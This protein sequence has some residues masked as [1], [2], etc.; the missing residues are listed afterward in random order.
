MSGCGV[1]RDRSQD[2]EVSQTVERLEV[3]ADLNSDPMREMLVVPDIG[4][5]AIRTDREFE[6]PRPDFFYAEAGNDVV[7]LNRTDSGKL[8]VVDEPVEQVW[9]EVEA[10]WAYNG[11]GVE[12]SD[13]HRG[14]IE[15]EWITDEN[16]RPGFFSRM[17]S[18]ITFSEVAG[19]YRDKLRAVV[20]PVEEGS[21][22]Q[23]SITLQHLRAPESRADADWQ[24]DGEDVSYKSEMM[25][26]LLHYLSKSTEKSTA[27]A[28][29]ARNRGSS[30]A[31]LGRD[32]A[33]HPVLKLTSDIDRSWEM[34]SQALTAAEVDVGSADR[35]LG[36]YY[37]TYET[38]VPVEAPKDGTI[39]D[40]FAWLHGDREE[41][42]FDTSGI[43]A[44]MGI[45][46]EDENAIKYSS[47]KV[48][49]KTEQEVLQEA[50]GYKIWLA[51]RVIYVFGD[52]NPAVK[53]TEQDGIITY[54]GRFQIQ[55]TR[56]SSG[57]YVSVLDELAQH[58]P[59]PLAEDL[60]WSIKENLPAG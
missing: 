16:T 51:G 8:I 44:A 26:D 31:F 38:T 56:R 10:F 30:R 42:T 54:A 17:L 6:V 57:V 55:L 27:K 15:T 34:L 46:S 23:T 13:T 36:K 50:D 40:F 58:A 24:A 1:I 5:A 52:V 4:T 28:L 29:Q 60:L 35:E 19:P 11:I 43:A 49:P 33:G 7:N 32:S 59:A 14:Y 20:R 37:I 2:Y 45:E 21:P 39:S 41:L 12:V 53:Q 18:S 3:P 25:Y 22:G 48:Q 47:K 9:K